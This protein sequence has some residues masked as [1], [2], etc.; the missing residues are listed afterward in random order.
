MPT[1]EATEMLELLEF[2]TYP[3]K[4][5]PTPPLP[6]LSLACFMLRHPMERVIIGNWEGQRT[7]GC[8][9]TEVP[10]DRPKKG[11]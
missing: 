5:S 10:N 3:H 7:E 9:M 11:V 8:P 1:N 6:I 4:Y 2:F